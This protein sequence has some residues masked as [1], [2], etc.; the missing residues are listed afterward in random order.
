MKQVLSLLGLAILGF[1]F[2]AQG[3]VIGPK[4]V[5]GPGG[6]ISPGATGGPVFTLSQ[7]LS[8]TGCSA[9]TCAVSGFTAIPAG[10]LIVGIAYTNTG[11]TVATAGA[12]GGGTWVVPSGCT[13]AW[14]S[15][16]SSGDSNG[17]LTFSEYILSSTGSPTTI[18]VDST[19]GS[20][21]GTVEVI[22]YTY[23]N[24]PISFDVGA[25][26]ADSS[27]C[28][29]CAGITLSL[30]GTTDAIIQYA[31]CDNTCAT[32]GAGFIGSSPYTNPADFP[33]GNAAG[34]SIN[35]SSGAAPNIAM[36]PT[37]TMAVA[38]ISFK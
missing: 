24:G 37:G 33:G 15:D 11:G 30:T 28:T 6:V 21:T 27:N 3:G 16:C 32:G 22:V 25:D 29:T 1:L 4:G 36:S 13:G 8:T 38:A 7:H 31:A 5:I 12:S 23:T 18:T 34:G 14:S 20:I 35:T 2:M 9:A 10:S 17:D 19:G 26:A